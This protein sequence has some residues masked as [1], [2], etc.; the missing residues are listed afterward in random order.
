M[1]TT[2][3]TSQGYRVIRELGCNLNGGRVTYLAQRINTEEKVVI[4]E[5]QFARSLL[6]SW[7]GF[8]AYEREIEVLQGLNHPGIPRYLDSFETSSGFCM[9][10]EYK[11]AQPLSVGRSFAVDEIKQIAVSIL[12]ILVYLQ[13]RIPPVFHRDIKPENILVDEL[14]NVYLVDFGFARIGS[15]NVAAS[16]VALG[17]LGFMAPEQIYSRKLTKSTDLYS[18]GATLVCLI[19]GTKSTAIDTLIDED[20]YIAFKHLVPQLSL[21]FIQWLTTMVQPKPKNRFPDAATALFALQPLDIICLSKARIDQTELKFTATQINEKLTQTI[22]VINDNPETPLVAWWEVAPHPSDPPHTP[23]SHDWIDFSIRHSNNEKIICTVTIDTSYL[24]SNQIYH[25]QILLHTNSAVDIQTIPVKIKTAPLPITQSKK[26][27]GSLLLLL[28]TSGAM[29]W[30][31]AAVA[32]IIA[33]VLMTVIGAGIVVVDDIV[34]GAAVAAL[35][36]SFLGVALGPVFG[37]V[38]SVM[39]AIEIWC[40]IRAGMSNLTGVKPLVLTTNLKK[41]FSHLTGLVIVVLTAL[42]GSCSGLVLKTGVINFWTVLAIASTSSSL[43]VILVYQPIR[44]RRL[45]AKYRKS[46]ERLIKP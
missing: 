42:L 16:S 3:F 9:V 13:N 14:I 8:K 35:V 21:S 19:T 31:G 15:T 30:T 24:V 10:Q 6:Q 11:N 23:Y 18:L 4:K 34:F 22:T 5:F 36:T 39:V 40:V 25:R 2:P 32:A 37:A 26:P 12:S 43:A 7:S 46:E 20:G 28:A 38:I 33:A 41:D 44:G 17:T 29:A 45:V 1:S 27:Y